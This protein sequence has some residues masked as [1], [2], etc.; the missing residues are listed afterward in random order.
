MYNMNLYAQLLGT[1]LESE[2]LRA[3]GADT[4]V[5]KCD[6]VHRTM[7]RRR[8]LGVQVRDHRGQVAAYGL[9]DIRGRRGAGQ[10]LQR[11]RT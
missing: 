9:G 5:G 1:A 7:F 2:T 3:F 11:H 10:N 8:G 4:R 6:C